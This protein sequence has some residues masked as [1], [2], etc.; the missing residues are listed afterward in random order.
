MSTQYLFLI[1]IIKRLTILFIEFNNLI[2]FHCP[3]TVSHGQEAVYAYE[4]T[5][6]EN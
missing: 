3:Y 4:P 6:T 2:S 1:P 5:V